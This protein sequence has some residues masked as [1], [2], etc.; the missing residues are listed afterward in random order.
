[1]ISLRS[2]AST[3]RVSAVPGAPFR[4]SY[5]YSGM[6]RRPAG[7]LWQMVAKSKP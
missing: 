3:A 5:L 6:L 1:M 2:A 7:Y 4:G